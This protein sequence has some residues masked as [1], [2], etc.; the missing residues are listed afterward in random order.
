M[1]L[2]LAVWTIVRHTL[3]IFTK[4]KQVWLRSK[5]LSETARHHFSMSV[6]VNFFCPVLFLYYIAEF[7]DYYMFHHAPSAYVLLMYPHTEGYW[8]CGFR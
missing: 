2:F 8:G 1:C 6:K 4:N 3:R 5:T 7:C